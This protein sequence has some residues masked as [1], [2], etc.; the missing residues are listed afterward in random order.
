VAEALER[1]VQLDEAWGKAEAGAERRGEAAAGLRG[2]AR[3]RARP[4][5]G[6]APRDSEIDDR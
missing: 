4:P 6:A 1:T 5:P 2:A 3:R